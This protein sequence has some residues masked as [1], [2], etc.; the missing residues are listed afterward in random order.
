MTIDTTSAANKSAAVIDQSIL[1]FGVGLDPDVRS[2]IKNVYQFASR[3]ASKRYSQEGQTEAWFN[4]FIETMRDCGWV[5]LQRAYERE[6]S[7]SQSLKL[8]AIMFKGIKVV[9]QAVLSNPLTDA[10]AQLASDALEGLGKVTE[11]QDIFQRNLKERKASTVGLGA[12]IQNDAGEIFLAVSAVDTTPFDDNNLNTVLFEWKS[13]ASALYT[14]KALFVFNRDLYDTVRATIRD[15][16]T[17][18]TISKVLD[19]DI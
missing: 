6:S 4:Q 9:G 8:G 18:N 11:A 10:L 2:D 14:G 7:Q 15:K 5:T 12:C 19:Y 1:A 13:S 16:L 3:V 17:Q